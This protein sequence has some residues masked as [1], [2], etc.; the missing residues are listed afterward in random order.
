MYRI[1]PTGFET[2]SC[3]VDL[4]RSPYV[5]V[6]DNLLQQCILIGGGASPK[7]CVVMLQ[8]HYI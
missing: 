4:V 3:L 6:N 1:F 7:H 5:S 8:K 2:H